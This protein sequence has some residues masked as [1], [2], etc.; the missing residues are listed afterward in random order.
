[1]LADLGMAFHLKRATKR[2]YRQ[3]RTIDASWVVS[4]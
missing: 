2:C 1:V 3:Q 4:A